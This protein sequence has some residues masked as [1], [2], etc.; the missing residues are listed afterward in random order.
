MYFQL[1]AVLFLP[2]L[3]AIVIAL[4]LRRSRWGGAAVSVVSAGAAFGIALWA[5]FSESPA[6]AFKSSYELLK[7]GGFTLDFGFL[8]DGLSRNMV[9]IV[10]FVGFLIHVFSVGY[11]DDDSSKSRFFAGMSFFMFSMTGIALSSNL[12][13]MFIFWELVGFSSYA[14]IAHYSDTEEARAASKKAFIVNRVGD[15]GFLL[16]II[17]CYSWLG[18]TDFSEL[19]RIFHEDPSKV[20]TSM[21]LLVLC[22]FLGKSAQFPLQVWLPDAMAGPTPVSALI[23]AATMVAAGVFMMARLASIGFL[24][25][26]A[27]SAITALCALMAFFAGLWALGQND[28]KKILA[29]STLAH[30]GLMGVGIGLGYDLAMYHLTTHAFFKATL[31]LAAGSVIHACGHQQDIFKLGGLFKKMPITSAAALVA[32]L[33]IIAIPYFSGYYSKEAILAASYGRSVDGAIFDKIIFWLVMGAA[34]LT[35]VYMGRLFFN[36]FCGKPHSDGA[37]RARESS[38]WMTLPLAVLALYSLAGAWSF[39]YGLL[40]MDG[41]MNFLMPSAATTFI[42]SVWEIHRSALLKIPDVHTLKNVAFIATLAGIVFSYVLY[43]RSRG[44]DLVERRLPGVYRFFNKHG[45]FDDLYDWYVAKVQQRVATLLATFVDLLLIELL[46]VRG[47][48]MVCAVIGQGFKRMH[49]ASAN[50]EIKWLVAGFALL[51]ILIYA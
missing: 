21:G 7:L 12:F 33:S 41:K 42:G 8:F 5:M 30:L 20:S 22:G 18:T 48:G 50:S 10:C 43:G 3:S 25:E 28:I 46:V 29:Y 14:L 19:A 47:V 15:L 32:T 13:M 23:H 1:N 26:D 16:G 4:F 31:F 49:D 40:W 45:W 44:Y 37:A 2:L 38:L 6:F 17:F 27:L 51:M 35:P 24:S 9:F 11:M 34:V 39:A 36:V